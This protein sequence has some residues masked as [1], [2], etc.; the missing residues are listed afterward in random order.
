MKPAPRVIHL[1]AEYWPYAQT[2]GLAEAVRGLAVH[3]ARSGLEVTVVL[4]LYRGV[5][6][7]PATLKP[8]GPEVT[9]PLAGEERA[10]RIW[11]AS[12]E[13]VE[14]G[15]EILFVEH[16]PFFD[17]DG[18]YGDGAA[19]YPDNPLRFALFGRAAAERIVLPR[20]AEPGG[21]PVVVHLHD[22][23]AAPA[24]LYL[25]A[26]GP[27]GQAASV[28][29]VHNAA[30]QGRFPTDLETQLALPRDG[31]VHG[32]LEW[33]GELNFL[34]GALV[35]ADMVST[36]SPTHAIELR[37]KEG[38]FG[39]DPIF[40]EMGD[41][42]VGILNGID[43]ELWNPSA[44]SYVPQPFAFGPDDPSGKARAKQA[45]QRAAG[46]PVEED[47]PLFGMAARLARQK[48][49]DLLLEGHSLERA[50]AQ[51][52]L[53]GS[54][55]RW[56]EEQLVARA[57]PERVVVDPRFSERKEHELLAAA[58]ALLMPSLYEP[59]GLTQMRAQ[60]YGALP[61]ARRVG[62]LADTIEDGTTGFLFDAFEPAA[63]DEAVDRAVTTYGA[64]ERWDAMRRIAMRRPVGW[65]EPGDAYAALYDRALARRG[66]A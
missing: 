63:L 30:F 37:T 34:K 36:V 25:P 35:L 33:F 47:I 15:P 44:D 29:T 21:A 9:L 18:L 40:R 53:L 49:I 61:V 28:V 64:A 4:P 26:D 58:D 52:I 50:A 27:A 1:A 11:R 54:G 38:G 16:D 51:F 60:R 56:Y 57:R 45:L 65:S 23:H 19:D 12:G 43:T 41:R 10:V 8:A 55:D 66:G 13:A 3:Q 39:L 6:E 48:G 7:G 46:L 2:G 59:C 17:R 31:G 22:W 62:G 42:L 24:L 14:P 5:R 32:A 20:A